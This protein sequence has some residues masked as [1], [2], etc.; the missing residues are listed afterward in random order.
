MNV[1]EIRKEVLGVGICIFGGLSNYTQ[2]FEA[3]VL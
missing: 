1:L 3:R 2:I